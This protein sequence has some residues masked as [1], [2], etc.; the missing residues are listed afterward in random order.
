MFVHTF[1]SQTVVKYVGNVGN[2]STHG[3]EKM[4]AVHTVPPPVSQFCSQPAHGN[5]ASLLLALQ[6]GGTVVVGVV[7]NGDA[8]IGFW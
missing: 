4:L 2:S 6:V 3:C 5:Q 8:A 1:S 7:G